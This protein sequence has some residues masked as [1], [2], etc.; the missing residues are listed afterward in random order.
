LMDDD[1]QELLSYDDDDDSD[2]GSISLDTLQLS[3]PANGGG[4]ITSSEGVEGIEEYYSGGNSSSF[5]FQTFCR[6]GN[7]NNSINSSLTST[8]APRDLSFSFG[9]AH[10]PNSSS[11][12]MISFKFSSS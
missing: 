5:P 8:T 2:D 12:T 11:S 1:D 10:H 6:I 7:N 3:Q 4:K 9:G